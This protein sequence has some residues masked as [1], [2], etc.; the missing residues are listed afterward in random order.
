MT[1]EKNISNISQLSDNSSYEG[2]LEKYNQII[3]KISPLFILQGENV[4][5]KSTSLNEVMKGKASAVT[6]AVIENGKVDCTGVAGKQSDDPRSLNVTTNIMFLTASLA[7]TV[8]AY[9]TTQCLQE[10]AKR[11]NIPA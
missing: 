2:N 9:C 7:K 5:E 1:T 4:I 10:Y 6:F 11:E 3:I 8:V